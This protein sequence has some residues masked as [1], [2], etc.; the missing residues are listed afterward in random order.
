MKKILVMFFLSALLA[1][2]ASAQFAGPSISQ[3]ITTVEQA[4]TARR[5][6]DVTVKGFVVKHLRDR[7]YLF[8][9]A[10]GEIRVKVERL[11]WRDRRVTSKT[12]V[13]LTGRIDRDF[14]ELYINV[15]RVDV[16]K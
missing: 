12:P 9:D 15:G 16:L 4:L 14:R 1:S 5:G 13:R 7:Y 3:Q 2:S 6:Q 8:R 11:R 10:T